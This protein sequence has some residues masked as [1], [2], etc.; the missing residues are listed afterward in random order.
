MSQKAI[1][2]NELNVLDGTMT[3]AED[4]VGY[5]P[6]I[7][8]MNAGSEDGIIGNHYGQIAAYREY[9]IH[10]Y[11]KAIRI[12]TEFEGEK[13]FRLSQ[14]AA[15]FTGGNYNLATPSSPVGRLISIARAGEEYESKLWGEYEI[16]D[17]WQF[18]RYRGT[19]VVTQRRNFA[20][21]TSIGT[22]NFIL[23]NLKNWLSEQ[24]RI[25]EEPSEQEILEEFIDSD[26]QEIAGIL[27][28]ILGNLPDDVP[29]ETVVSVVQPECYDPNFISLN[30][31]FYVNLSEKQYDAA[32]TGPKGLVVVEGIA[33]S[34]KTSVALGRAKAL[35]QLSQLPR[36][37]ERYIEDFAPEAQIGFVRTGELI[38]YLKDTCQQLELNHFPVEEYSDVRRR[39]CHHWG[40]IPGN[41]EDLDYLPDSETKIEWT[42]LVSSHFTAIAK[43]R[44][45]SELS[46]LESKSSILKHAALLVQ[47]D[48][49]EKLSGFLICLRRLLDNTLMEL[50]DNTVWLVWTG[51]PNA[52]HWFRVPDEI[53]LSLILATPCSLCLA[54]GRRH[55][56]VLVIPFSKLSNWR[57][58][59]PVEGSPVDQ[60]GQSISETVMAKLVQDNKLSG[61]KWKLPIAD[62]HSEFEPFVELDIKRFDDKALC[63]HIYEQ[64]LAIFS[65]CKIMR[66]RKETGRYENERIYS[67]TK[68]PY[69]IVDMP[70]VVRGDNRT[71]DLLTKR[72][73][74]N[75]AREETHRNLLRIFSAVM[76][77][78]K[79]LYIDTVIHEI[80]NQPSFIPKVHFQ[81][82]R[83]RLGKRRLANVDIDHLLML[84]M[85]LVQGIGAN[86]IVNNNKLIE[87]R[88]HAAVFIDEVQDFT[89]IQVRLMSMLANP[90]H[91]A[92]TVVGDMGQRLHRPSVSSIASCFLAEQWGSAQHIEL[93][94]NIRQSRVPALGRLSSSYRSCFIDIDRQ[95]LVDNFA[96]PDDKH[97]IQIHD[98]NGLNQSNKILPLLQGVPA[99]WT[100][101]IVWPDLKYAESST[102]LLRKALAEYGIEIESS[103]RLN[104]DKRFIIHQTTPQ[105]IKGLE[106]DYLMM[107]GA[108]CYDLKDAIAINEVYV[109][110]SRPIQQLVIL[111]QLDQLDGRFLQLLKP[112]IQ[113]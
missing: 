110:L 91:R 24:L 62:A 75:K 19:D 61:V 12:T 100:K 113:P 3:Y 35:M 18:E 86:S 14:S 38:Q 10:A 65:N 43:K 21:M 45:F 73:I 104:L 15:I 98:L 82:I 46:R 28:A 83:D 85:E 109:C 103:T 32:H 80:S 87:P 42:D 33:G 76:N 54:D 6:N 92:V 49:P 74:R 34:G 99:R 56:V 68:L 11:G 77:S 102:P 7:G 26:G 72:E 2:S 47:K 44:I 59:L 106:F 90:K 41:L 81:K 1:V 107:V 60:H 4:Q 30:T 112:F 39:L 64:R 93:T 78:P 105:H 55:P 40:L 8:N 9:L 16:L 97:G 31:W 48:F 111:G 69:V 57:D 58:W 13:I 23:T 29:P 17:V 25:R 52:T 88:Y 96:V 89:E 51:S 63:D 5:V 53:P 67:Y 36:N 101:V 84:T 50:F 70:A 95:P 37:D 20:K 27:E 22:L 79:D 108:E 66:L 94:E 71:G